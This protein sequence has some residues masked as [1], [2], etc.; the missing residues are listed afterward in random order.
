MAAPPG[1][2]LPADN[3]RDAFMLLIAQ[4]I[5][6]YALP[7][8]LLCIGVTYLMRSRLNSFKATLFED[9][10][11]YILHCY[12]AMDIG[13]NIGMKL[14]KPV[15]EQKVLDQMPNSECAEAIRKAKAYS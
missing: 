1:S 4:G 13:F 5:A 6:K 2:N 11:L 8:A 7:P 3:Q 9:L 10:V 15:F 12:T 14:F